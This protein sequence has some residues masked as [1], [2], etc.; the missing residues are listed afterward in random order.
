MND[1]EQ[2]AASQAD[3]PMNREE[4][5]KAHAAQKAHALDAMAR[6]H[7]SRA[8]LLKEAANALRAKAGLVEHAYPKTV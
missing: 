3:Q 2:F 6:D 8:A 1:H 5:A 7:E 4:M